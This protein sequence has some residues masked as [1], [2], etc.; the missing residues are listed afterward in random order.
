MTIQLSDHFTYKKLAKFV[1]PSVFMM[2]FVSIYGVIDGLFVSWF[3]GKDSFASI[4]FIM[5]FIMILGGMG[6]M[7]GSGGTALVAKT[8]GEGNKR[9]ANEYFSMMV[10]FSVLLGIALTAFGIAFLKPI[11]YFLGASDDMISDCLIY[12]RIVIGFTPTFL[13]QVLP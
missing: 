5:P 2:V 1:L 8:L 10:I 3:A 12:G 6:F 7:I 4:N 11:A 13:L 9:R